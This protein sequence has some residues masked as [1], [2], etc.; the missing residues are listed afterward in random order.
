MF[1]GIEILS[2]MEYACNWPSSIH[3]AL[4]FDIFFVQFK[5]NLSNFLPAG[6][7]F[8]KRRWYC[9]ISPGFFFQLTSCCSVLYKLNVACYFQDVVE[10]AFMVENFQVTSYIEIVSV[11]ICLLAISDC[12]VKLLLKF[13]FIP[14]C[15][16]QMKTSDYCTISLVSCPWQIL[17]QTATGHSFLLHS[18]LYLILM[19]IASCSSV[20][21]LY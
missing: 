2:Y 4:H 5:L 1:C 10:R 7:W 14:S 8:F 15:V 12:P 11:T 9:F 17:D 6:W 3:A 19:G 16:L 13:S 21:W 20:T 18:R